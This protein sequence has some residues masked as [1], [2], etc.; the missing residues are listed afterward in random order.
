[1]N[2]KIALIIMLFL[3]ITTG[4]IACAV[5]FL[6]NTQTAVSAN[7]VPPAQATISA[8]VRSTEETEETEDLPELPQLPELPDTSDD[9]AA[10]TS[11]TEP[12]YKYTASHSS[13]R[14]FIRDGASMR[15]KIIGSL[16][17]GESGEV[18]SIGDSWVLLKYGDIEGYVFKEYLSLEEL[19]Q[20]A[21]P[22][23]L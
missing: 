17:P 3:Y 14:L 5:V 22:Q 12:R 11:E 13:Q 10:D 16:Q 7:D 6:P 4:I 20:S 21:D 18:I 8:P 19:P 9:G 15:A 23:G 1:M 2:R